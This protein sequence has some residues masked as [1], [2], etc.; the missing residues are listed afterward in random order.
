MAEQVTKLY[1]YRLW[2]HGNKTTKTAYWTEKEA[3]NR[4]TS[5]RK[6]KT[7]KVWKKEPTT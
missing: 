1:L 2:K 3:S 6:Y 4:N 7:G 5:H